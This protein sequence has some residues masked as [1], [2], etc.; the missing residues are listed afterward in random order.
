MTMPQ[1]N[2]AELLDKTATS[3]ISH[4]EELTALD[5]A[6]GDADHGLNMKRG[7]EFVLADREKLSAMALPDALKAMGM[8]LVMKVGGASG[9]LYGTL[10]MTLGKELPANPMV[11]DIARALDAAILAMK[12]R[13]KADVGNKTM[14]DVLVPVAAH[15][16]SGAAT[17]IQCAKLPAPQPK[18]QHP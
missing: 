4:T 18:P 12:A 15:L 6:I 3:I 2:I 13:G 5:A 7:F 9:P 14:L 16:R 11:A 8:T 17:L 1:I 10:L